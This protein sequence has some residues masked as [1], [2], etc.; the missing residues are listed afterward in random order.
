MV[1]SVVV[2]TNPGFCFTQDDIAM[3][4]FVSQGYM[5]SFDN[6][7]FGNTK[8]GSFE[9]NEIG[10]NFA[11]PVTDE[12]LFGI[13]FF[14][15]DMGEFSN[16][17]LIVDWASLSYTYTDWMGFRAGKLKLPFGLYNRKRD[18][19]MLRTSIILPQS[20]YQE[21]LR[22]FTVAIYGGSL[23]GMAEVGPLGYL[24]YEFFFG[25]L[26]LSENTL[27]IIELIEKFKILNQGFESLFQD[28]GSFE[29]V[30]RH[31]EGGMLVWNTPISGLRI[32][33]IDMI[34]K[35]SATSTITIPDQTGKQPDTVIDID[36]DIKL[37]EIS[38]LSV[39]YDIGRFIFAAEHMRVH[40]GID[41][42]LEI[43]G[44]DK[45]A[46]EDVLM[47][48][49]YGS[50]SCD[51][52]KYLSLGVSY[53]EFY[54][55]ANDQDGSVFEDKGYPDYFAWQKETTVSAKLNISDSWCVK[56]ETHFINGLGQV[57]LATNPKDSAEENWIMYAIKTSLNF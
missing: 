17:E 41:S 28:M 55:D 44:I 40:I 57:S 54:P 7:Y 47:I 3:H 19:D 4:G 25:T 42:G 11:V 26:P 29:M 12:L 39:E 14:S 13:Q 5:K 52:N 35:G 16:N 46:I 45:S 32:G 18:A 48:G 2:I 43:P 20:F 15:R 33:L 53:G 24:D 6:N 51:V 21:G 8:E 9:F 27:Y 49:Y 1:V 34:G 31:F 30:L 56:L 38:T 10:V 37:K 23:Y 36:M 22:E 50:I